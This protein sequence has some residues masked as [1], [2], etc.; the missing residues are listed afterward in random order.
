MMRS[1]LITTSGPQPVQLRFSVDE[2]YK[3]Y[4]LGL[5]KDF[6]RVEIIDG[7]L[8]RK[9]GIGDRHASVV[10]RLNRFLVRHLD[11]N[12]LVRIQNPLRLNDYDEP[13]PDIVLADL[14]KYDG[15]RHPRPEETFLVIEVADASLGNDR[16][17]KLPLYADAGITEAWI[18]NL[19]QNVIEI[20]QNP[21]LG[22]YQQV[23][24]FKLGERVESSA[25]PQIEFEVDSIIS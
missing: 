14:T 11:E 21:S 16:N 13:E 2:Y 25:L 18:V 4:E 3:M 22:I 19:R 9:M 10:D 6:E 15:R 5:I 1:D 8:I 20:H 23:K 12:I 7:E 24:I 17:V